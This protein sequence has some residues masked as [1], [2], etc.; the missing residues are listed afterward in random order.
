MKK[1]INISII[2]I[3]ILFSYSTFSKPLILG[4]VA[5]R[6]GEMISKIENDNSQIQKERFILSIMGYISGLNAAFNTQAGKSVGGESLY[7]ETLN[8]CKK[9]PL[10]NV[11]EA[12]D[13]T[14]NK[15]LTN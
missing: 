7:Y 14:Y 15:L 9:N 1:I 13:A 12:T 6:C 2:L 11:A 5:F 8:N 3:V 10:W 4:G